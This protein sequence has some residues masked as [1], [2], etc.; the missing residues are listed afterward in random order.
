MAEWRR[1][2]SRTLQC[3][4]VVC[5][6]LFD[7]FQKYGRGPVPKL[8]S[9]ACKTKWST[10]LTRL[11]PSRQKAREPRVQTVCQVCGEVFLAHN[12]GQKSCS[13]ECG[14]ILRE[15]NLPRPICACER[16]GQPFQR[17]N[18]KQ[19]FCSLSCRRKRRQ[20]KLCEK[21]LDSHHKNAQFCSIECFYGFQRA[22]SLA[23][24]NAVQPKH[25][26]YRERAVYFGVA[27]EPIWHA[28]RL[29][30]FERDRWICQICGRRT[31]KKLMGKR[32]PNA[33]ELD[34]RIPMA[35]GGGHIWENLQCAC[36]KC[37]LSK[38]SRR[39]T[40]QLALF[41]IPTGFARKQLPGKLL[42]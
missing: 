29:A 37:N 33:P 9:R 21:W 25:G 1:Y 10:A 41:A 8:C 7:H 35:A 20:C 2:T 3:T 22:T 13:Y 23:A 38:G 19:R 34:H 14:G 28:G 15:R 30:I 16:C 12:H 4:C 11:S 39:S 17:E 40:G 24:P 6:T 18:P 42:A 31:P 32:A 5:G 36:H 26:S 27:Y